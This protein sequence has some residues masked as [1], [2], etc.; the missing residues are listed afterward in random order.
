MTLGHCPR[1]QGALKRLSNQRAGQGCPGRNLGGFPVSQARASRESF[2]SIVRGVRVWPDCSVHKFVG[3]LP[4]PPGARDSIRSSPSW[5]RLH[6]LRGRQPTSA[7]L[8]FLFL[9]RFLLGHAPLSILKLRLRLRLPSLSLTVCPSL[10]S[11]CRIVPLTYVHY[12][13]VYL[14]LPSI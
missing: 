14:F 10:A 9:P 4:G 7:P 8:P 2:F 12:R 11:S 13:H 6:S 5:P 1:A 3:P